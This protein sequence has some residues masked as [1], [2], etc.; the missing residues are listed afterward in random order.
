MLSDDPRAST[1]NPIFGEIDQ[2]GVGRLRA[3][4]S[5]LNF[6]GRQRKPIR[7]ASIIGAD[8]DAVLREMSANGESL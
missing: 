6:V 5:P 2:P 3:A 7:P 1:I 4:G 8:T